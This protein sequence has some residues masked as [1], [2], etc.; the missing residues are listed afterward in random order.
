MRLVS[1]VLKGASIGAGVLIGGIVL[2]AIIM[3]AIGD[4]EDDEVSESPIVLSGEEFRPMTKGEFE[5]WLR[6]RAK[7]IPKPLYKGLYL[8]LRQTRPLKGDGQVV[9]TTGRT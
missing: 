3:S 4:S 6:S 2:L 8:T 5:D 1:T 7:D 9:W